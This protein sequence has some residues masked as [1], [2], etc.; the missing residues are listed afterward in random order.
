MHRNPFRLTP[1][2]IAMLGLLCASAHAQSTDGS[3][4]KTLAPVVIQSSADASAEGLKPAHAGGQVATGGRVGILG[5]QDNLDTPFS[6]TSY[7]N[8]LIQDRQARSVGEVLQNDPGVRVARGFGNFQESYFMRGFILGSDDIAYNGLYSILPRQYIATELIER[9]EVLRGASAFLN[10]AAPGGGLGGSINLLP[11]RA[12]NEPL[13]RV[14]TSYGSGNQ[15]GLSTDIGRRFGDN[16]AFGVRLSAGV[17]DGDTSIDDEASHLSVGSIGLDWRSSNARVSA[18]LGFQENRLKRTRTNVTLSGTTGVPAAPDS[19]SNW[20]QS[21]SYSNES[22]TF[23]TLRGEYDFNSAVTGWAAYGFRRSD[24]AN[25][26]ANLTVTNSST[27]DGSA[28]RFDNAREDAVDTGEVGLRGKLRTGPVGHEWVMSAS[29]F[30]LDKKNAWGYLYSPV[31]TNLYNPVSFA[32]PVL[33]ASNY[34]GNMQS[35]N[36]TGR[37]RLISYALGD[38]ASLFDDRLL[39]TAGARYQSLSAQGWAAATG[40]ADPVYYDSRISPA[41]GVVFKFTPQLSVYG[42]Y[43]ESLVQGDTAPSTTSNNA[44]VTN[45][46]SMLAPY[47]SKQKEVGVKYDSGRLGLGLALFSTDKPRGLINSSNT[48]VAEGK[49][50]H[51]GAELTLFGEPIRGVRVLGGL[52]LLDAKQKET[53]TASTEGKRVIGVPKHQTTLGLEFDVPGVQG[54]AFDGRV[55]NTGSSYADAANTLKVAGWTRLDIGARYRMDI[56]GRLVTLRA[57]I[58]NVTDKNYW[59]SVGGYPNNGYLVAG[60]PRTYGLSATVDF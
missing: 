58:D 55:V 31:T 57:R 13:T 48:Y 49:D 36:L 18:D 35:P 20:A 1:I 37:T 60:A 32:Q 12:T 43:I 9:V 5:S 53:G 19:S 22:D 29:Y 10:G 8:E 23:G 47:V 28:Y 11:K 41:A 16:D 15:L 24:E 34:S 26:L 27:G 25:S 40:V 7:T 42:N 59:A 17:H 3:D 51:Q 44:T 6:I 4:A 52:T 21:W 33:S 56:A 46:G 14:T 54:L 50:R 39:V 45:A 30:Q 2:S 38:T